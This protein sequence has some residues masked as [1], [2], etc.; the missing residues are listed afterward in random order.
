MK[1]ENVLQK[2]MKSLSDA[3][4]DILV[5]ISKNTTKNIFIKYSKE[6]IIELDDMIG[7]M[8]YVKDCGESTISK[9]EFPLFKINASSL[10]GA[11]I[12]ETIINNMGGNWIN[13]REKLNTNWPIIKIN[14][15]TYCNPI[16]WVYVKN[17]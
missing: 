4:F 12:G 9:D 17:E 14:D 2:E 10:Y 1:K 5:A 6:S 15:K 8:K 7:D 3:A 13:D 11:Y 16:G